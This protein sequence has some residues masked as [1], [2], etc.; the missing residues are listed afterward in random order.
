[1][2]LWNKQEWYWNLKNIDISNCVFSTTVTDEAIAIWNGKFGKMEINTCKF[3]YIGNVIN[4]NIIA[5]Y[6]GLFSNAILYNNEFN[7]KGKSTRLIKFMNLQDNSALTVNKNKFNIDNKNTDF[8]KA[9][10]L[11]L[12]LND[13][14][15]NTSLNVTGNELKG[16]SDASYETFVTIKN[17]ANKVV[18]IT[19]NTNHLNLTTG[20]TRITGSTN[21]TINATKN[22]IYNVRRLNTIADCTSLEYNYDGNTIDSPMTN[23]IASHCDMTYS[24][25]NNNVEYTNSAIIQ[26]Y[27]VTSSSSIDLEFENNSVRKDDLKL[28][29][30]NN[31]ITEKHILSNN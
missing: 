7:I 26:C 4:D 20:F 12:F 17:V 16:A 10:E 11:I 14:I 24:F 3:D 1:M 18:N 9:Y 23:Y 6:N 21:T 31:S 5:L 22:H 8:T 19:N 15:S 27:D 28:F 30:S 13:S 29:Y 25:T 2:G